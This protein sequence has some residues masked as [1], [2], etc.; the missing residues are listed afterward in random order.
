MEEIAPPGSTAAPA[1]FFAGKTQKPGAARVRRARQKTTPPTMSRQE[2][3]YRLHLIMVYGAFGLIAFA[4]VLH[5]IQPAD[6]VWKMLAVAGG[7]FLLG[8]G[9]NGY[10]R[11]LKPPEKPETDTPDA[12]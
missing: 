8:K 6:E 9:S 3:D 11:G 12:P 7:T 2:F 10:G 4:L 5:A 1:S